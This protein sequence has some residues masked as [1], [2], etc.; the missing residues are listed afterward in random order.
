MESPR[1]LR[2]AAVCAVVTA[3]TT[4]PIHLLDFPSATLEEQIAL[5]TN[6]LYLA[7]IGITVVH[8]CLV[9]VSMLGVAFA[10]WRRSPALVAL[11][12]LGYLLFAAGELSR[13]FL[14]FFA[15]NASWRA[16]YAQGDAAMRTLLAAWPGINDALFHLFLFGFTAGTA[17]Y[18]A[19]LL[20]GRGYTRAVGAV[21]T[22]WAAT[23]LAGVLSGVIPNLTGVPE[24]LSVTLQPLARVLIGIWLWREASGPHD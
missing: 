18:A 8:V 6:R 1:F 22:I 20:G 16:S 9:V 24:T 2:V 17:F 13:M 4:L 10:R 14:A 15:L 12:F 5:S 23:N 21:F 7:R 3:V 19:A 11:G